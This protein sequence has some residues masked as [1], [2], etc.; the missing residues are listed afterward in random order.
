MPAR[1]DTGPGDLWRATERDVHRPGQPAGAASHDSTSGEDKD[2][3]EEETK[4]QKAQAAV[5]EAEEAEG[6]GRQAARRWRE[7]LG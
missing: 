7:E 5:G 4:G 6:Q 2:G 3:K 1:G